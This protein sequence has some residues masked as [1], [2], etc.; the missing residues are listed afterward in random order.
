VELFESRLRAGTASE[1]EQTQ[2]RADLA[3]ARAAIPAVERRIGQQENLLAVLVGRLPGPVARGAAL[4]VRSLPPALPAGLPSSLLERRPD[5]RAAEARVRAANAR[6]GVATASML[7]RV[8]L[9]A[10][11]GLESAK[12][13]D[14][15]D[16]RS[17][18]WSIGAGLTAPIFHGGALSAERRRAIAAWEE[19]VAGYRLAVQDSFRDVAD[20]L[21]AIRTT[22]DLRA[23]L[24]DAV[25]AL[26]RSVELASSRY[27]SGLA[28]YFEVLDAQRRLFPAR[29]EL[30]RAIRDEHTAVIRLYRALGGGWQGCP[31]PAAVPAAPPVR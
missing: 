15:F 2:A 23:Q 12:A 17:T 24:E 3:V 16:S 4:G 18:I 13:S 22:R 9:L 27:Q 11:L 10:F 8:D 14:F 7:P 25:A 1:L 30:A 26:T 29:I 31:A 5:V 28:A 19:A 21:L 6:V 20:E